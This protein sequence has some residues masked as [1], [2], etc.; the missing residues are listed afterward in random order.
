MKKLNVLMSIAIALAM[1]TL[2]LTAQ[3]TDWRADDTARILDKTIRLEL[4]PST[5]HLLP[6]E[7]LALSHLLAAGGL[8]HELYLEQTHAEALL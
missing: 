5:A 2:A 8:M 7:R 1:P 6:G 4:A 3:E